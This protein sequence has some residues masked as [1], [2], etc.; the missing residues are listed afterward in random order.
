MSPK[1]GAS[2]VDR[3]NSPQAWNAIISSHGRPK[4]RRG[5]ISNASTGWF[6]NKRAL[7]RAIADNGAT[8]HHTLMPSLIETGSSM[9]GATNV[10][11][12]ALARVPL[13]RIDKRWR[14]DHPVDVLDQR[15]A[16]V[17]IHAF[18]PLGVIAEEY[19]LASGVRMRAHDPMCDWRDLGL[20]LSR[21]RI[22]AVAAR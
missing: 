15:P 14:R 13:V 22:F 10:P 20:L 21:E 18:N 12:D 17:V 9:Q 19:G 4:R 6:G 2:S 11:H 7:K 16:F 8:A 3:R 5:A 1:R